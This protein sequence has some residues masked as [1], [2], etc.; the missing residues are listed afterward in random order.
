MWKVHKGY[1]FAHPSLSNVVWASPGSDEFVQHER[2]ASISGGSIFLYAKVITTLISLSVIA[3]NKKKIHFTYIS[4]FMSV[5]RFRINSILSS[6][7]SR[8]I[9]SGLLSLHGLPI[10]FLAL[11]S[12]ID[13]TI[14]FAIDK[15]YA[16]SCWWILKNKITLFINYKHSMINPTA[17]A[18]ILRN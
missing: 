8:L 5:T 11:I 1:D 18:M 6:K 4:F 15:M 12:V 10:V 17:D 16:F 2:H 3:D 9:F 14:E 13:V 7:L